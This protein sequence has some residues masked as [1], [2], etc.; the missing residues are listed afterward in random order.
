MTSL[1]YI[2]MGGSENSIKHAL[3]PAVSNSDIMLWFSPLTKANTNWKEESKY[4]LDLGQGGLPFASYANAGEFYMCII[5]SMKCNKNRCH[6]YTML[7]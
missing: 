4:L 1:D 2:S 3:G 7:S 6:R 5:S